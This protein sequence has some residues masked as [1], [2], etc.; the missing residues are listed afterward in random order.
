MTTEAE[1]PGWK[2]SIS[3][4]IAMVSVVG[5]SWG[6]GLPLLALNLE[7]MTGSG[8]VIG[9]NAFA[10]A[11]S[12]IV[13]APLAPM[14]L[15]RFP[16][17]PLL[18][19]ALLFTSFGF[20]FYK[21]VP[22]VPMWFVMRFAS[23]FAI[24]ILFI[25]SESWINQLAPDHLRSR[26]LAIYSIALAAGFAIGGL[27][28]AMLG[29]SGWAPFVTAAGICAAGC[30]PLLASGPQLIPPNPEQATPRVM[31]SYFT[32]APRIMMAAMAFGAIESA[33][34]H[35]SPVW[36]LRSGILESNAL[37]LVSIGSI[38]V[39]ALQFPIGW[40]G[41]RMDR[42]RL[43]T[44][45]ASVTLLGP[46][47]MWLLIDHST[48]AVYIT[49]FFYVGFGEG[50]YILALVLV[51]QKFNKKDITTASAALV[52]MYGLGSVSSPLVIGPL[53]DIFN[54]NGAMFGLAGFALAY[55]GFI[56]LYRP[57]KAQKPG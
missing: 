28:V 32:K 2:A 19:G 47:A 3:A 29:V 38:G 1:M 16:A 50:M 10:G 40:L 37:R 53:M 7:V 5:M 51:G 52:L 36:A 21:L 14:I 43:L 41:D 17:R 46:L 45:C 44:I 23:G 24:S 22:S 31:L 35:F 27:L 48:L 26:M 12:I 25:A 18:I 54:P 6:I 42:Y 11:I 39:I 13:A 15:S 4:A 20:L 49:Y 57:A 34:T 55:L 8:L 33:A 56:A 30:L 9:A